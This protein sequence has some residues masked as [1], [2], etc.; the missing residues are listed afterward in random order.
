MRVGVHGVARG[1]NDVL[2]YK[3]LESLLAPRM[4]TIHPPAE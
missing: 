4:Q 3:I 1:A 2:T